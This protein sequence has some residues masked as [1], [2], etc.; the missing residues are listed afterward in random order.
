M[1]YE[2]GFFETKEECL[3]SGLG[4]QWRPLFES[5]HPPKMINDGLPICETTKPPTMS[6]S[7]SIE[8]TLQETEAPTVDL[9]APSE[10]EG[11]ELSAGR[12][13]YGNG[14][15]SLFKTS[16]HKVDV[17]AEQVNSSDSLRHLSVSTES[18]TV[19]SSEED[20]ST[21]IKENVTSQG[22]RHLPT[23]MESPMI[24]VEG[25]FDER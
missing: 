20:E 11:V 7:I 6:P 12:Y 23:L 9:D 1:R 10:A 17:N 21:Y 13:D 19:A 3:G 14:L 25:D 4:C 15:T 18:Q 2:K 5:C 16:E 22:H 8:R 24:V